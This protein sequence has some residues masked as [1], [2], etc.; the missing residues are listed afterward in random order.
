MVRTCGWSPSPGSWIARRPSRCLLATHSRRIVATI[1]CASAG[2]FAR[3]RGIVQGAT[4]RGVSERRPAP[5][6]SMA[7]RRRRLWEA[8]RSSPKKFSSVA[9]LPLADAARGATPGSTVP[10]SCRER[11]ACGPKPGCD[12]RQTRHGRAARTLPVGSGEQ[13]M[14][15]FA[16]GH[17]RPAAH[18]NR[19]AHRL[20]PGARERRIDGVTAAASTGGCPTRDV[21]P[22]PG[23]PR[24]FA[25]DRSQCGSDLRVTR[26]T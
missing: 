5:F 6:R 26:P 4:D 1:L 10:S 15:A 21:E 12:A 13:A 22:E 9:F 18:G 16:V 2:D 17:R 23:V 8:L 7:R 19:T 3:S 20:A 11:L 24:F 14:L 25:C